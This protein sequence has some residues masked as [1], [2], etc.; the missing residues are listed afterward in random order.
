MKKIML[1]TLA[2]GMMSFEIASAD[3]TNYNIELRD[4]KY[5]VSGLADENSENITLEIINGEYTFDKG[6]ETDVN[7]SN[8]KAASVYF[9][10]T[11]LTKDNKSFSFTFPLGGGSRKL[12][13]RLNGTGYTKP[14]EFEISYVNP[15]DYISARGE[16]AKNMSD[17]DTFKTF[18]NGADNAF[19]LGCDDLPEGAD[20]DRVYRI[21]FTSLKGSGYTVDTM[22]N[23][24]MQRLWNKCALIDLINVKKVTNISDYKHYLGLANMGEAVEKWYNRVEK[25]ENAMPKLSALI[26]ANTYADAQTFDDSIRK[27]LVLAVVK[28]P[29]GITNIGKIMVDFSDI[30]GITSSGET[31]KYSTVAGMDFTSFDTY[32]SY[33]K[34]LPSDS[35]R[36]NSGGGSRGN[37]GRGSSGFVS[38]GS[39]N[40]NGE[41]QQQE[42]VNM[43]FIDLD[44]VPW[45]YEAISTLSDMGII[46]GREES[47][48]VPDDEVT[49]E[50]F[51]KMCVI[52]NGLDISD[53]GIVFS[54][55]KDGEW[56]LGYINAAHKNNIINGKGDGSF[57]IGEAISRQDAAVILYNILKDKGLS[58]TAGI[59]FADADAISDY[60]KAA[61]DALSANGIINGVGDNMFNPLG[62]LTRAE[63]AKLIF[64]GIKYTK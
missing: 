41:N 42:Q 54:D 49:R 38:S 43:P 16:L 63:A 2:L 39:V 22:T 58:D 34:N 56:Y 64:E 14:T 37:S 24:E 57:G 55:E 6:T 7:I 47:K 8:Y 36:G 32:L 31:E 27:N 53:N 23:E 30:T 15:E 19:L 60:A 10:Q 45:A 20:R 28:Y 46:N 4:G 50:E 26:T 17:F 48:F 61:T 33:F 21:M 12:N 59:D 25:T 62:R 9:D 52:M 11:D 51:T 1:L 44:T 40:D 5:T 18:M 13:A 35:G 3:V 29:D